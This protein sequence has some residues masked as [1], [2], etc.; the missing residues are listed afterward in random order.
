MT[1]LTY[2]TPGP[3]TS[4]LI[5]PTCAKTPGRV[6]AD[7]PCSNKIDYNGRVKKYGLRC[8][9]QKMR[10]VY[11]WYTSTYGE[12]YPWEVSQCSD[13]SDQVFNSSLTC[14]EHLQHNLDFHTQ[15]FCNDNY[16]PL[17]SNLIC[18]NKTQWL[19]ERD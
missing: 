12:T 17:F 11:P 5:T 1:A 15:N 9:C 8:T 14:R 18:S 6:W 7:V 4:R 10:C 3:E 13:K 2:V 19:S 16:P